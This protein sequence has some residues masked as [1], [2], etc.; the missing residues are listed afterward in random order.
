MASKILFICGSPRGKA[1][2]T[3]RL[4]QR[5]AEG[6]KSVGAEAVIVDAAK[7]ESKF[8][9]CTGCLG[10]Q[11]PSGKLKCVI[12]DEL[13]RLVGTIPEFDTVV[14]ASPVY[15]FSFPAQLK[16]VIDRFMSLLVTQPDL[17]YKS[18]LSNMK[19]AIVSTGGGDEKNSGL[20][21]MIRSFDYLHD[22]IGSPKAEVFFEKYCSRDINILEREDVSERAS[23]FGCSLAKFTKK[24]I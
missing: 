3:T 8:H 1:S 15:F 7:L 5:V 23:K 11:K 16:M 13:G 2:N 9:G 12:D 10:C 24:R 4:A 18:P 19:F 17:S 20:E 6:A 21:I 14:F 22:L